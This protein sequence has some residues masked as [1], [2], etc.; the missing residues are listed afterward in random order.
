M[1]RSHEGIRVFDDAIVP[2]QAISFRFSRSS[3]PGGQNVNKVESRVELIIY[4]KKA[5]V[6]LGRS[7]V[8]R[9]REKL[10]HRID[11][12]GNLHIVSSEYREQSRNIAAA[13]VKAE[14]LLREAMTFPR[15]RKRTKPSRRS[16]ERRL[17]AKKYRGDL[18]KNRR[19]I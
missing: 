11:K 5:E 18:K 8:D 10:D 9:L 14:G 15:I 2:P 12:R 13:M 17:E 7:G 16:K 3:G 4:L 1:R 19:M 6:F